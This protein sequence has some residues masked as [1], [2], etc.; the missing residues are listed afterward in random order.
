MAE[1]A[2]CIEESG[3][4]EEDIAEVASCIEEKDAFKIGFGSCTDKTLHRS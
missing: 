1:A 4:E 3:K 2:F